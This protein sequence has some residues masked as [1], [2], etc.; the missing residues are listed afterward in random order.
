MNVAAFWRHTGRPL[1]HDE[2]GGTWCLGESAAKAA[3]SFG[4]TSRTAK[5]APSAPWE[6][7]AEGLALNRLSGF[8][9]G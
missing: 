3:G 8:R 1:L 6:H 4:S 2:A 7:G 5:V 9:L